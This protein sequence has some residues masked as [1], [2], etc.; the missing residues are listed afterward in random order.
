YDFT[1]ER[2]GGLQWIRDAAEAYRDEK[3]LRGWAET[4]AGPIRRK[5]KI[6][7]AECRRAL[8][9]VDPAADASLYKKA[10][11]DI[12][13]YEAMA[14]AHTVFEMKRILEEKPTAKGGGKFFDPVMKAV[15]EEA[16][17]A[18]DK[19]AAQLK[20]IPDEETEREHSACIADAL[21]AL[22]EVTERFDRVL[23]EETGK[24]SL[25]PMGDVQLLAW[26]VV[27]HADAAEELRRRYDYIFID[28]YQDS[29]ELQDRILSTIS[30]G[31]NL[32]VVGDVKQCIYA[33]RNSDPALF[34]GRIARAERGDGS[35]VYLNRNFRSYDDLLE[36][37]NFVFERAMTRESG[38]VDYD[39]KQRLIPRDDV[40]FPVE[41]VHGAELIVS[42]ERGV[43][44][45]AQIVAQ[46]IAGLIGREIYNADKKAFRRIVPGD[47]AILVRKNSFG[48]AF[49]KALAERGI[50]STGVQHASV[51]EAPDVR[52][53][54]A[55][56]SVIESFYNDE[57]LLAALRSYIGGFSEPELARVRIADKKG[58]FAEAFLAYEADD[59]PGRKKRLFV[60][61]IEKWR[62]DV[63]TMRLDE[64]L[65]MLYAETG[66]SGYVLG[67]PY[68]RERREQLLALADMARQY[69]NCNKKGLDG[70]LRYL[71]RLR[72]EKADD[73]MGGAF[74]G[75]PACVKI[76]TTHKSKGLQFPV[77]F[78]YVR[79]DRLNNGDRQVLLDDK[80]GIGM[81]Y[82][83]PENRTEETTVAYLAVKAK[84]E[85]EEVSE[86]I[87]LAYVAMTRP[88]NKLYVCCEADG[89]LTKTVRNWTD[90]VKRCD[91][92]RNA[93][94]RLRIGMA[95]IRHPAMEELR[96]YRE[97]ERP[98]PVDQTDSRWSLSVVGDVSPDEPEKLPEKTEEGELTEGERAML[99]ASGEPR[100]AASLSKVSVSALKKERPVSVTKWTERTETDETELSAAQIGTATHMLL[101]RLDFA[102]AAAEGVGVQIEEMIREGVISRA[103]ADSLDNKALDRFVRGE[104]G[105]R[106][107]ARPT[108]KEVPF[109]F[110]DRAD[111][112]QPDAAPGDEILI[113]GIV[114]CACVNEDGSWDIIDYKTDSVRPGQE[115]A[116]AERHRTQLEI[117]ARAVETILGVRVERKLVAFLKTGTTIAL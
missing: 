16:K 112:Y 81:R 54:L 10:S 46:R 98:A 6:C 87:R 75:D 60:R 103:E 29:N 23:R 70:F 115:K 63:R 85:A 107:A 97:D 69:V 84:A 50:A 111:R 35:C 77:A 34:T 66:F 110:R 82:F 55:V 104:T 12:A 86:S 48:E 47:V 76:M 92:V 113:Q 49:E 19:E 105:R 51:R 101:R 91:L 45:T 44:R 1:R 30:R 31:D 36:A 99:D 67:L 3:A 88:K 72:Q 43:E 61:R 21:A 15:R 38:G 62:L 37:V 4:A 39:E 116:A 83:D 94:Q 114:D 89:D 9:D 117:Y 109:T 57:A 79:D 8:A 41:G 53:V 56:L 14:D 26:K 80:L 100:R 71:E 102:R 18:F 106:I 28:E 11:D 17:K 40:A 96:E 33:F 22:A 59:D 78:M 13:F 58:S 24:R 90:G 95:L 27:S 52:T 64:F 42:R 68:G 108:K 20:A 32:F 2:V 73:R 93:Y 7:A 25:L 5:A 65:V 74:S